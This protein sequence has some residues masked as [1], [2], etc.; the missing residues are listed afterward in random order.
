MQN[1]LKTLIKPAPRLSELMNAQGDIVYRKL[2]TRDVVII[3]KDEIEQLLAG[4]ELNDTTVWE[5]IQDFE[6]GK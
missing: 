4:R 1:E 3:H 2:Y 5:V 6:N